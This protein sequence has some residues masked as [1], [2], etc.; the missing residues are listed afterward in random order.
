MNLMLQQLSI[1]ETYD[2][3]TTIAIYYEQSKVELVTRNCSRSESFHPRL[4]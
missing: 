4:Q 2:A 3:Q 1:D